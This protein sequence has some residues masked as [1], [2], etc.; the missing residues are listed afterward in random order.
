MDY[1][2]KAFLNRASF[3][4]LPG[5]AEAYQDLNKKVEEMIQ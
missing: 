5:L 1:F 2:S 4:F 3:P